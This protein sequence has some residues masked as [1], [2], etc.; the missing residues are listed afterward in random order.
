MEKILLH[1]LLEAVGGKLL[2]AA[3]KGCTAAPEKSAEGRDV[4]PDAE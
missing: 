3:D 4:C 2:T 1:E